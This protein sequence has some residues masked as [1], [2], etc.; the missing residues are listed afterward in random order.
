MLDKVNV[1][2]VITGD[3]HIIHIEQ[4]KSPTPRR[5]VNEQSWVVLTG[6][7]TSGGNSSAETLKLGPRSLFETV[8]GTT[9][10]TNQ[11]GRSS[12]PRRRNHV[13]LLLK[14]SVKKGILHIQLK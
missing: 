5:N 2:R 3:D 4:K 7:K 12:K 11:A 13:D 9:Q 6:L 8:E 10:P 14:I 1:G